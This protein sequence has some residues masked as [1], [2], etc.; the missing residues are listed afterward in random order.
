MMISFNS[1]IYYLFMLL[2]R[3]KYMPTERKLKYL[4]I[5]QCCNKCKKKKNLVKNL[6]LSKAIYDN[7]VLHT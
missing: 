1:P 3:I 2:G 7:K 6:G 5:L 4:A